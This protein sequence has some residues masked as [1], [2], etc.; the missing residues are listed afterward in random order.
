MQDTKK[1]EK[2]KIDELKADIA[3]N[4]KNHKSQNDQYKEL[5]NDLT[6]LKRKHMDLKKEKSDNDKIL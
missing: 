5:D 4:K 6:E 2:Q 1:N 3:E